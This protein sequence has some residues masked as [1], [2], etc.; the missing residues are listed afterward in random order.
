ML[1]IQII[2]NQYFLAFLI[3]TFVA[4]CETRGAGCLLALMSWD[5]LVS[6]SIIIGHS[7]CMF[8]KGSVQVSFNIHCVLNQDISAQSK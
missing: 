7:A 5:S 3:T 8:C 6:L 1:F 2:Q 4:I